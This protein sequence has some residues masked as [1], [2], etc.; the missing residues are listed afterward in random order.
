MTRS[1]SCPSLLKDVTAYV[2]VWASDKTANYSKTFTQQLQDMGAQVSKTF[3]KQVTH[4]IFSNGHLTTWKKAKEREV[5]LVSILWV[6]RCYDDGVHVDEELYP[7]LNDARTTVLKNRKHRC[8]QPRDSPERTPENDKRMKRKLDKMMKNFPEKPDLVTDVSPIIIDEENGAIYSPVLKRSHYMAQR[9]KDMKEKRENLSPTASQKFAPVCPP[10]LKS[11]LGNSSPVLRLLY[12]QT[13]DES[14][15][16]VS[17]CG[18]SPPEDEERT[19][20]DGKLCKKDGPGLSHSTD[21]PKQKYTIPLKN[22]TIE[23]KEEKKTKKSIS[24]KKKPKDKQN[25]VGLLEGSCI[26]K[27]SEG[28]TK[29]PTE[30][31]SRARKKSSTP[32]GEKSNNKSEIGKRVEEESKPRV[33]SN[34]SKSSRRVSTPA[35]LGD[36]LLEHSEKTEMY[37]QSRASFSAGTQSLTLT[38]ESPSITPGFIDKDDDVFEDYFLQAKHQSPQRSL[39][40]MP[41][42]TRI[43]MP[44]QLDSV[45]RNRKPRKSE[46][47][48]P[49]TKSRKNRKLDD[50]LCNK[51]DNLQSADVHMDSDK[52]LQKGFVESLLTSNS[53]SITVTSKRRRLSTPSFTGDNTNNR[54]K[55]R[56]TSTP[57]QPVLSEASTALEKQK[58]S[59]TSSLSHNLERKGSEQMV[60]ASLTESSPESAQDQNK[61][62]SLTLRKRDNKSK[63]MRTLVM[64]SIASEKRNTAVQVVKALGGFSI[65]DTVSQSTTHV[66]SG[67]CQRTLNILLGIARGCWILSFEWIL[68]SLEKGQW[69][70]EEP[71]EL[72]D[73]FP[74][75]QVI[76]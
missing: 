52:H 13:D 31:T 5:K 35:I 2:D 36:A 50:G 68:R 18:R 30:K 6:A 60:G 51:D 48:E 19:K 76:I 34:P 64:T 8:M 24:L 38:S 26:N 22:P 44:F 73:H 55:R 10:G 29:F 72:S 65:A 59:V 9:L 54:V 70:P 37:K 56:K 17:E 27:T 20:L 42:E 57:L 39:L 16:S 63:T 49:E 28:N 40:S 3:S 32:P 23:H 66:V 12:D 69:I 61:Q 14:S 7:A 62:D 74:A 67:G 41:V 11:S 45:P 1:N 25:S 21:P 53:H 15:P 33:C 43:Q 4:V 58:T 71:Y 47:T 46:R 75:A